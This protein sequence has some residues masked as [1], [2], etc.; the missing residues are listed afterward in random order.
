MS[1]LQLRSEW[2]LPV[3]N[4]LSKI[5][6]WDVLISCSYSSPLALVPLCTGANP[7]GRHC[8]GPGPQNAVG[9]AGLWHAACCLVEDLDT[10]GGSVPGLLW[11]LGH[12]P[13]LLPVLL[14]QGAWGT[15]ELGCRHR[16]RLQLSAAL[17]FFFPNT[18]ICVGCTLWAPHTTSVLFLQLADFIAMWEKSCDGREDAFSGHMIKDLLS[19]SPKDFRCFT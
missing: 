10:S 4:N 19:A 8:Q 3:P 7:T 16:G 6:V 15:V 13:C 1:N 17:G 12:V 2:E 11:V 18:V 14:P 9:I 5:K